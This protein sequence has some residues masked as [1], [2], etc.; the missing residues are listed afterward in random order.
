M[1]FLAANVSPSRPHSSMTEPQTPKQDL[2]I[3]QAVT[4]TLF[5]EPVTVAETN[6]AWETLSTR[7]KSHTVRDITSAPSQRGP[8]QRVSDFS[9]SIT[10]RRIWQVAAA[11][12]VIATAAT[13]APFALPQLSLLL[14]SPPHELIAPRGQRVT[15]T[16]PDGSVI[17]LAAGSTARWSRSFGKESRDIDLEGEAYFDVV[18]DARRPFRVR[19]RNGVAEDVGT[20]FAMRAWPELAQVEVSV[21]EGI[22]D[23]ADTAATPVSLQS[24]S[25][26]VIRTRLEAGQ[27]G[28]LAANGQVQVTDNA[29]IALSWVSGALQF[30]DTPLVQALP[31]IERWYD[32]TLHVDSQLAERRLSARFETQSLAQLLSALG[33]ALNAHVD[34]NGRSAT[35]QSR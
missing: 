1:G 7:I 14:S 12:L 23:F 25:P 26:N 3:Q 21:E 31:V 32:V 6:A 8:G 10:R 19:A 33:L 22:V 29:E 2:E 30:E 28:L 34:I 16:L 11:V 5:E 4:H 35:L 20:R 17:T 24:K 15:A 9:R 13:A 27:R 18:H